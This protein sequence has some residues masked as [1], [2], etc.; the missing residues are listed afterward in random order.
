MNEQFPQDFFVE[1]LSAGDIAAKILANCPV[2]THLWCQD[3]A[4]LHQA[5]Q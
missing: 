1:A 4:C 5:T 3:S 2:L